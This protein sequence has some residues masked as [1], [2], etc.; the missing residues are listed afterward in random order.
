MTADV[1]LSIPPD[2]IEGLPEGPNYRFWDGADDFPADPADCVY[3][4]V[5]YMKPSEVVVR[6]LPVLSG[7]QVVQTLSAGIDSLDLNPVMLGSA[8][9][10]YAAV[11][12]VVFR[13]E[14]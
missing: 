4:V 10:G 1:W 8:G 3:Y 11:D 2:T 7:V 14:A 5:P 12:S 13:R 6:P 9:E